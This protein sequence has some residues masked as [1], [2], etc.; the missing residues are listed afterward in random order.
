[1]PLVVEEE[2][3]R[4]G[5]VV[6]HRFG[7]GDGGLAHLCAKFRR[8]DQRGGNFDQ[9]LMAALDG[10]IPLPQMDDIAV[11]IAQDL[12]FNMMRPFDIFLDENAAVAE[13]RLCFA[14][15]NCH[16]LTQLLVGPDDPQAATPAAGAGFD[17]DRV[18]DSLDECQGLFE[19]GDAA[20]GAWHDWDAA[21]WAISRALTL[22]PIRLMA[23]VDGPMKVMPD[24]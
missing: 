7:D 6:V 24:V 23:C 14:R 5:I 20:F 2:L 11:F 17:H 15:G 16:I 10:A 22:L 21:V 19:A 1:M 9:F 4:S 18:A 12:K 8:E 3:D 13:G